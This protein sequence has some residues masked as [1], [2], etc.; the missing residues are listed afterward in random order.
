M[1]TAIPQTSVIL[2]DKLYEVVNGQYLELPPRGA[3]EET[4]ANF[5][6]L[7]MGPFAQAN[8][9]GR[10][11]VE[12]LFLLD[13]AANLK[14]RPDVAFVSYTR[15]ARGKRVPK[16]E[17]WAVVPDL[18]VEVISSSN[19]ANADLQKVQEYFRAGVSRVWVIY[20]SIEQVYVYASITDIRVLTRAD[21]LEG[22]PV[23]PAFRVAVAR[24]HLV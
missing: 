9:L 14:R 10:C 2:D 18:A 8:N 17:A 22:D 3:Y 6:F 16:E 20:P 1:S 12:V 15:W 23:L 11:V 4:L 24:G 7:M 13:A 19:M 21:T 5:L